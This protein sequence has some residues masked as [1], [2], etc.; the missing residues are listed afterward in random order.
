M[1]R[2]KFFTLLSVVAL[3]IMAFAVPTFAAEVA[4]EG[5]QSN[6]YATF[7]SLFP[8]VVAIVL[9]LMVLV[10][11]SGHERFNSIQ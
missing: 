6:L 3:I 4:E 8:P 2:R 11:N 5:Y 10:Y 9:A 7:W 1:N